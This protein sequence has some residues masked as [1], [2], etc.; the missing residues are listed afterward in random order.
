M[1][2]LQGRK[3]TGH[4]NRYYRKY[5]KYSESQEE[6]I[7]DGKFFDETDKHKVNTVFNIFNKK[8]LRTSYFYVVAIETLPCLAI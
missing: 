5:N 7:K 2:L 1:I 8:V 4:F 3:E 6:S